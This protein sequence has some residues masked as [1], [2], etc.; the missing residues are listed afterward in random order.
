MRIDT[1]KEMDAKC[2]TIDMDRPPDYF[3]IL[4]RSCVASRDAEIRELM[5]YKALW[6][7]LARGYISN[8]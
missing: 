2:I 4:M 1:H 5:D 6:W 8:E 3:A 7:A